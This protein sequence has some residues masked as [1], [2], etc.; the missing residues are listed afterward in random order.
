M[1]MRTNL[2]KEACEGKHNMRNAEVRGRRQ[3]A[4]IT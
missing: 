2:A 4:M 1:A 3:R